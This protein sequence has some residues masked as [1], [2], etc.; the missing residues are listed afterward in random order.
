MPGMIRINNA[1]VLGFE[2]FEQTLEHIA[3][4]QTE[5]GYPPFNI[6]RELN[7]TNEET[8]LNITLA[9]AGFTPDLLEVTVEGRD[10]TII[11]KK[12]SE[13]KA[14]FLHQGIATRQFKKKFILAETIEV[15][16]ATL[17]DGLL[18]IK[19]RKPEPV[20]VLRQI[21]ISTA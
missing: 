19:L 5:S 9:V 2:E 1:H 10:L 11:G 18:I 20:K 13:D 16:S 15:S 21:P 4:L 3:N 14:E 6:E 8:V 17:K 12:S 7:K